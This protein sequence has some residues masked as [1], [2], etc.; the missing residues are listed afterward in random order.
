M[1]EYFIAF[2]KVVAG[3]FPGRRPF[4]DIR[5]NLASIQSLGSK[6]YLE[7]RPLGLSFDLPFLTK[8]LI[9]QLVSFGSLTTPLETF[10]NQLQGSLSVESTTHPLQV[11]PVN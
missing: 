9:L 10:H 6:V 2:K 4:F 1:L 5:L 3:N 7:H 8:L 11:L